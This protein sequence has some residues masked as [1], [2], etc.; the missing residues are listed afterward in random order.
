MTLV[1]QVLLRALFFFIFKLIYYLNVEI[2]QVRFMVKILKY[3]LMQ[4]TKVYKNSEEWW[5]KISTSEKVSQLGLVFGSN[6]KWQQQWPPVVMCVWRPGRPATYP[7]DAV[8]LRL[9]INSW[10]MFSFAIWEMRLLRGKASPVHGLRTHSL[11]PGTAPVMQPSGSVA[12]R[13]V[14]ARGG[15]R[16]CQKL[17]LRVTSWLIGDWASLLRASNLMVWFELIP[18]KT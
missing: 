9:P 4:T 2:L 1:I 11:S 17:T 18:V 3:I 8:W 13:P 6:K 12:G 14:L 10:D 7:T 5:T 15:E 16:W